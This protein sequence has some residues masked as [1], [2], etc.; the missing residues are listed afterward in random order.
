VKGGAEG[1][2]RAERSN[3]RK[4]GGKKIKMRA[5]QALKMSIS[6]HKATQETHRGS[7]ECLK[8]GERVDISTRRVRRGKRAEGISHESKQSKD[9]C[10]FAEGGNDEWS[11]GFVGG[12]LYRVPTD[13]MEVQLTPREMN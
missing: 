9:G 2:L 10:M 3:K 5:H 8:G 11:C 13:A 12:V 1:C 4:A 6:E 7:L